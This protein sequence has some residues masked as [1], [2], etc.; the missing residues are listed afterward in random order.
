[1]VILQNTGPSVLATKENLAD[2]I[3]CVIEELVKL[4]YEL[5][6]FQKLVRLS[7]AA[8]TVVNNDS[9]GKVFNALTGEQK[10]L[11]DIIVGLEKQDEN[12]DDILPWTMLKLEPKRPTTNNVRGFIQ[13][14]NKM[15][16]LRQKIN[17]NLDFIAPARIEQLRDE[18]LVADIDDMKSMRSI[19][20]Y[21]LVS[22][23]FT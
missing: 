15:R 18:A 20:R 8:R 5:P 3:N 1:M 6:S 10:K 4:R 16:S 7:R 13:C 21:A 22:I 2:I 9:Y 14:V 12:N 11:I 17:I 19:K 23:L